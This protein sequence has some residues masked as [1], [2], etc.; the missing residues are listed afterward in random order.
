MSARIS[1]SVRLLLLLALV[2]CT[3]DGSDEPCEAFFSTAKPMASDDPVTIIVRN[4][5]AAPVYLAMHSGGGGA[6]GFRRNALRLT[7]AG[8]DA[9]LVTAPNVCDFSCEDYNNDQCGNQCSDDGHPPGPIL[10]QPG[11]TFTGGWSGLYFGRVQ[12]PDHCLPDS[13]SSGLECGRWL[14]AEPGDFTA[15][16]TVAKGWSCIDPACACTVNAD[17]W[18]QLDSFDAQGGAI[19]PVALSAE[20]AFPGGAAEFVVQ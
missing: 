13:C 7:P 18:C 12:L 14:E 19:D 16:V 1:G 11:E 10:L 8:A 4:D 6:V 2:G 5:S 9:A 20:L 3:V 15:A 17:G